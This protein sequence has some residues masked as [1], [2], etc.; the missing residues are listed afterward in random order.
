MWS[1]PGRPARVASLIASSGL[2]RDS[3]GQLLSKQDC[4]GQLTGN[5]SNNGLVI[6]SNTQDLSLSVDSNHSAQ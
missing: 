5:V 4:K 6:D 1:A 2:L 3:K